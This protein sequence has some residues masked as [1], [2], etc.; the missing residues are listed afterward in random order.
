M[1]L[2]LAVLLFQIVVPVAAQESDGGR[3]LQLPD[4]TLLGEYT[5]YLRTPEPRMIE[6]PAATGMSDRRL[7]YPR[8]TAT[9]I[10]A[11]PDPPEVYWLAI[12]PSAAAPPGV[13][14]DP[15]I[16]S[17]PGQPPSYAGW[18]A[19]F[20]YIPGTSAYSA[21]TAVRSSS[22]WDLSAHLS[23]GLA[24]G[25]LSREL[26]S[27]THLLFGMEARRRTQALQIDTTVRG[28]TFYSPG[29]A[30]LYRIALSAELNGQTGWL[31]WREATRLYGNSRAD[32]GTQRGGIEQDLLLSLVGARYDLSLQA[33]GILA[34]ELPSLAAEEHGAFSLELG[35][36]HP[37][38]LLRLRAGAAALYYDASLK[39]YPSAG[40]QFFPTKSF[41]LAVRAAPFLRL[42]AKPDFYAVLA[43]SGLP[44]VEVE[45]GYSLLTELRL[46]PSASFGA[47]VSFEWQKGRS[48]YFDAPELLFGEVNL[49]T[50]TGDLIWQIRPG[51]PGIR[52]HLTGQLGL[53]FPLT[54]RS[55]PL[56]SYAGVVWTTD[57]HKLP[58]EF[59]I[60]GLIGDFADDGSLPFLFTDWEIVSELMTSVEANWKIGKRGTVYT[61]L[62]MFV[63]EN[64]RY[65]ILVGYGIRG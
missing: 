32:G 42:P 36:M 40:L 57:F 39:F 59:I 46:D 23:F 27:P 30:P 31:H 19:R 5:V 15:D 20:D 29:S 26:N 56:S 58:V 25:W 55:Y 45:G 63:L 21:L 38:S 41:S 8:S 52:V 47:S 43:D 49:G 33:G 44:Q 14:P 9:L 7:G 1:I 17:E 51:R 12:P 61:G 53:P 22:V 16:A 10:L 18:E 48:Y 4:V 24:D 62:E 3:T 54:N 11:D 35:W 65:R 50:V 60:K 64:I 13:L 6:L 28:G 37:R 34:G 2:L